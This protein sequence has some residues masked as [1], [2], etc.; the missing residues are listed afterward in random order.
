MPQKQTRYHQIYLDLREKI[1]RGEYPLGTFLPPERAL[2]QQYGVERPTLRNALRLLEEQE[3]IEKRRGAGSRVIRAELSPSAKPS[4]NTIVYAMPDSVGSR[5]PQPY[6]IEICALLEKLCGAHGMS[7]I[8]TQAKVMGETLPQ[9]IY[10]GDILGTIWVSEVNPQ[11]LEGA[12]RA[13]LPSILFC[14]SSKLFPKIN[15]DDVAAGYLA[16][17]HLIERGCRRIAH[18]SGMESYLNT[19]GRLEGYRRALLANGLIYRPED[20]CSGDW[21]Y[22]SGFRAAEEIL[23]SAPDTDGIFAA[24]DRMACGALNA[25]LQSGRSIPENLK[26]VGVDDIEQAQNINIPLT[27]IAFSQ[28]DIA[29]AMF[30]MLNGVFE[31]TPVPGEIVIPARLILRAST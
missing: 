16:T 28:Q 24:N 26:I 31:R 23:D 4:A 15:L 21:S 5:G 13:G 20:V 10:S 7:V 2:S 22:E 6:H 1:Q 14:S 27:T 11:L 18:I 3:Y 29:S 19:N 12:K 25:A 8:Y 30:M 9:W 17:T